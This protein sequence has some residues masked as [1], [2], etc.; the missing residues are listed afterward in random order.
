M[1]E[2]IGTAGHVAGYDVLVL[3]DAVIVT[4]A[5]GSRRFPVPDYGTAIGDLAARPGF[6]PGWG[7]FPDGAEVRCLSDR[8]HGGYGYALNLTAP[9]CSEWGY[10][11][12]P[13]APDLRV[14]HPAIRRP[15]APA[16]GRF[17]FVSWRL[18]EAILAAVTAR[19]A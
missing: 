2:K 12:S 18:L 4:D 11:A 9:D 10:A 8:D 17:P 14:A 16:R 13:T 5:D 1:L 15:W 19:T 6:R 7:R 3:A